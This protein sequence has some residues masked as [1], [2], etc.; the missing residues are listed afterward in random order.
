[1]AGYVRFPWGPF[2][3]VVLGSYQHREQ[4]DGVNAARKSGH[5][6]RPKQA[7]NV[8]SMVHVTEFAD[9]SGIV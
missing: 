6:C 2:H 5:V 8:H 1:M 7:L 4:N 9:D 3:G